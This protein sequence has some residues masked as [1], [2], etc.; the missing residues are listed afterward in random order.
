MDKHRRNAASWAHGCL[1][2]RDGLTVTKTRVAIASTMRAGSTLLKSLLAE[3]PDVAW[4]PERPFD[5]PAAGEP[6]PILLFKRPAQIV[7]A[8]SYP[9]IP[10]TTD[11]VIFLVRPL[12]QFVE[13]FRYMEAMLDRT[14]MREKDLIGYYC[15]VTENMLAW[16]RHDMR[17]HCP[18]SR[19]VDYVDLVHHPKRVTCE[20]LAWIGSQAGRGYDRYATR[21][22]RWGSDDA[23]PMIY[24]GWVQTCHA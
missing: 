8:W 14:P 6:E 20:L 5:A 18:R 13:S 4:S 3:A 22:F 24:S 23:G 12:S 10:D 15:Q 16:H 9:Q 17:H 1:T 7:E 11:Y 19:I 2:D 21:D